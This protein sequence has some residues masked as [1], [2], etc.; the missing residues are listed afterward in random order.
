MEE[1]EEPW[2][3]PWVEEPEDV[4]RYAAI[5]RSSGESAASAAARARACS[6]LLADILRANCFLNSEFGFDDGPRLT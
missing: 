4:F 6:S 3:E 2:E 1:P 5:N